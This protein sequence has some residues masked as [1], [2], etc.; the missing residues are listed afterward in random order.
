M[1]QREED[2]EK[3]FNYEMPPFPPSLFKGGLMRKPDKPSLCKAIMKVSDA[4]ER[5]T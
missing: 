2:V 1:A 4:L 5:K 3:Y